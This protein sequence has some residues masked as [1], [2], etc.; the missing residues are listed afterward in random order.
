MDVPDRWR[1]YPCDDYFA[2]PLAEAGYWDEPNVLWLIEPGSRIEE[3]VDAEFLQVGR[4][5]I[6]SIGFGYRKN[7]AGFWA[8]HRMEAR[9]EYLASSVQ[10][11]LDNWFAGQVR[12]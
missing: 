11:F 2:S 6:D 9:F 5:G 8:Y 4:P 1:A 10:E 3:D 12:V 7:K